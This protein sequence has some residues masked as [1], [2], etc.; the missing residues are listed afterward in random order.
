V[1][2]SIFGLASL[3]VSKIRWMGASQSLTH[4]GASAAFTAWV[5]AWTLAQIQQEGA[6]RQWPAKG[7]DSPGHARQEGIQGVKLQKLEWC[8]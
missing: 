7:V 8:N 3:V 5:A 2:T 1:K 4:G 6:R